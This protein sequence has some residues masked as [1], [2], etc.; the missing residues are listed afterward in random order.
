M[1]ITLQH[2]LDNPMD[3]VAIDHTDW[4][5]YVQAH[6]RPLPVGGEIL[7][8]LRGYLNCLGSM[9]L[10]GDGDHYAIEPFGTNGCRMTLWYDHAG[11]LVMPGYNPI[12]PGPRA[13]AWTFEPMRSIA[14]K[15]GMWQPRLTRTV[16]GSEQY[17]T[18][19]KR[20]ECPNGIPVGTCS[21]D[22][23]QYIDY[24]LFPQPDPALTMHGIWMPK[25]LHDDH[26]T[27]RSAQTWRSWTDGVPQELCPGGVL[28]SQRSIGKYVAA[29]G[30]ITWFLLDAVEANT[31]HSEL[32][33]VG[34]NQTDPASAIGLVSGGY[35]SGDDFLEMVWTSPSGEPG[36]STWPTGD[37]RCQIDVASIGANITLGFETADTVSGHF[38][39]VD[40][41]ATAD[42]TTNQSI[43]GLQGGV[44]NHLFTT[45]SVS[46]GSPATSDRWECLLAATRSVGLHG[47]QTFT[48]DVDQ[49]DSFTD[50][51]WTA[52]AA[53][54]GPK[55]G[56]I[57]LV[58]AGR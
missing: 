58:G 49:A 41:G 42:Q 36:V 34:M 31:A 17:L 7:G 45:G 33:K 22:K 21:G 27:I 46:W 57:N 1:R 11:D 38:A 5:A 13:I 48:V 3:W 15:G 37:Y 56:S 8:T 19:V 47:N 14:A 4:P 51:P 12:G 25:A 2:S 26:Q 9:G 43:E 53:A 35:S 52:P 29:D 54:A 32:T 24:S 10:Y 20:K 30:T 39:R 50:G 23:T 40:S 16:Y 55:P 28:C 44:A 6:K 18:E